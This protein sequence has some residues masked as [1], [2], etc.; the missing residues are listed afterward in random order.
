MSTPLSWNIDANDIAIN[1][2]DTTNLS[3]YIVITPPITSYL[4]DRNKKFFIVAPKGLGKTLLLKI[5]SQ[6]IRNENPG[7]KLIPEDRLC[8]KFSTVSLSISSK[9]LNSFNNR[10]VW[11]KVWELALLCHLSL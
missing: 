5:K 11:D 3:K 8:E 4:N 7:Y 6:K 10:E 1:E 9:E 2:I